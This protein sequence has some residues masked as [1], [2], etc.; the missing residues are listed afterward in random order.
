MAG[1]DKDV[2]PSLYYID[3]IA[4]MHKLE[5]G[6]FGYA[7]E[8]PLPPDDDWA[9]SN[10]IAPTPSDSLA[11]SSPLGS[12][13]PSPPHAELPLPLILQSLSSTC[14]ICSAF[15]APLITP[16]SRRRIARY[17]NDKVVCSQEEAPR[18]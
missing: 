9:S 7:N 13:P 14:M 11:L 18:T 3:Y 2:G 17:R 5:K 4:T 10:S 15:T 16:R 1:Y 6:A 8:P 12:R